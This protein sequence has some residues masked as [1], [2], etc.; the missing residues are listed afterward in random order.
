MHLEKKTATG[1]SEARAWTVT[2]ERTKLECLNCY[3]LER[4]GEV[5]GSYQLKQGYCIP[6]ILCS[7]CRTKGYLSLSVVTARKKVELSLP[8]QSSVR[9]CS[10]G[11]AGGKG[12]PFP[13]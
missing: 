13:C 1:T 12:F 4:D 2:N 5:I 9:K 10:I 11:I 6:L 7:Y 3:I 8:S